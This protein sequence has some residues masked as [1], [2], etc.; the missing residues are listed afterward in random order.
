MPL[1]SKP[2]APPEQREIPALLRRL[3][4]LRPSSRRYT[5]LILTILPHAVHLGTLDLQNFLGIVDSVGYVWYRFLLSRL[6]SVG[7]L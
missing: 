3:A 5:K 7:R 2:I 6:H 4:S 1:F